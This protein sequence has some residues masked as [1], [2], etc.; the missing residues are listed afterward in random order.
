[1]VFLALTALISACSNSKPASSEEFQQNEAV[2]FQ[3]T[4]ITDD[5]GAVNS[6]WDSIDSSG[7]NDRLN[8]AIDADENAFVISSYSL[9]D[10]LADTNAPLAELV[11]IDLADLIFYLVDP[12]TRHYPK[13]DVD[14]FYPL[15]GPVYTA[16]FY[17][18]LDRMSGG[19]L[20]VPDDYISGL[21]DKL[22]RYAIHSIPRDSQG[23]LDEAWFND[24]VDELIDD[25]QK[26]TFQGDF[27]DV[28]TALNKLCLQTDYPMWVDDAGTPLNYADILP[29][30]DTNL[31]LGNAVAGTHDLV[32][33]LNRLVQSSG[34]RELVHNALTGLTGVLD[35]S[36]EAQLALRLRELIVNLE[37]NFTTGGAEY[38]ANPIYSEDDDVVYS[39]AELGQTLR[40]MLPMLAQLF[41]R[42]D[43]PN[44]MIVDQP[45]KP[46][47]YPLDLMLAY[48]K[49]IGFDPNA[50]DVEGSIDDVLRY[51]IY[52]RDRLTS[53]EA[54]PASLLES[55]LFLTEITS[56]Y[57]WQDGGATGEVTTSTDSRADHGHG[58][59]AENLT[60]NDSLFSIHMLKTLNLLGIYELSLKSTDGNHI[61]RSRTPYTLSDVDELYT[62]SVSGDDKDYRFFFDQ[63]YG[64]LQ[65][66][67]GPGPGDLGAPDG[68][69]SDGQSLGLNQ[70]LAYAPNGLHE[71]QLSAWTMGWGVRACFKGEG[72]YYYADPD[73]ETVVVDGQTYRQY[74]RPDGKIYALV[75][76][77]GSGYL[78][79]TNDG[80]AEDPET[81]ELS[82]NGKRQRD[83]R[84]KS[85]WH[86]DYY[87]GHYTALGVQHY[88]T[89]DNSSGDTQVVEVSDPASQAGSLVYQELIAETDPSRAC[90]SPEEAF[91]RNYQWV[92]NEKKMVLVVPFYMDELN[93][94][95]GLV[96]QLIECHGWS[97]LANV[98]KYGA[99][100]AWAKKG[101]AGLS[102]LPGDYRMEVVTAAP[103]LSTLAI[104]D[105]AVYNNNLDCGNA[106][107]PV[108][109]HNLAALTRLG[110]PRSPEMDRGDG[111]DYDLGSQ[112]FTVGDDI[113][114]HRNA[115]APLLFSLLAGLRDYAPAYDPDSRPGID[116]GMR[117][118]LNQVAALIKPLFYYNRTGP[119][120]DGPTHSWIPRVYGTI[121]PADAYQGSPFLKSSA[122][123]YSGTPDTWFG[124]WEERRYYQPAVLKSILNVM[125]DSNLD[126]SQQR[127]NG[128]LPLVTGSR[129]LTGLL[130][131]LLDASAGMPPL[132]HVVSAMKVTEGE[133]IRINAAPESNKSMVYPP[134]MFAQGVAASRDAYGAYTQYTGVRN[135][136]LVVDVLLDLIVGQD[137][138]DA[139][140][141]GYGLAN[142]PDD[143]TTDADWQDFYDDV[144][145]LADLLNVGSDYSI[146]PNLLD[147]VDRVFAR[148][149]LYTSDEV[150]G[151]LYTIGKVFG[152]FDSNESGWTYQGESRF[153]DLYNML[154]LRI[155]SINALIT[156]N[157]VADPEA[158]GGS[159][160]SYALGEHYHALVNL[161]ANMSGPDG[162]AEFL[163][164]TTTAPQDWETIFEDLGLFM[165]SPDI[166][167]SQSELWSTVAELLHQLAVAV[168]ETANTNMVNQILTDYGFQVN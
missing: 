76:P 141:P 155:P 45:G 131:L 41:M 112:D 20:Q 60:L 36:A 7:V 67:A 130:N 70:Y 154:V 4:A 71:T 86:S 101:T 61:Y 72:P 68:G 15:A 117:V 1:M 97:G 22:L 107:P 9:A 8:T 69:N 157:E 102:T 146:T 42:S 52:G 159:S 27:I 94:I 5:Y 144:G 121:D 96:F 81:A 165:A 161:L 163:L 6:A 24:E 104:N 44:A 168:N 59:Y 91:Y 14:S 110:F 74:L 149:A 54:W 55:L 13:V 100:H 119:V 118:F 148:D 129:A 138:V 35:P 156:L 64:V 17:G 147:L 79:P 12:Q 99:N 37:S 53:D 58:A 126:D 11:H 167:G 89:L 2:G 62:G 137:A 73:A 30:Q 114:N 109:G 23:D 39:D 78:Y 56:S 46:S 16:D 31:D 85:Q 151:L 93:T 153:E 49:S 10:I 40:E 145:T 116:A 18:F 47:V 139:D 25:L 48:L 80:D 142:Y 128:I 125:I 124:S 38:T 26:A 33:W 98:R 127:M 29:D 122:D 95:K 43:R 108:V 103:P 65:F 133:S 83:N 3:L 21:L 160:Q 111:G 143:K 50:I 28:T 150:T 82:F 123:F 84:Y 152:Y 132:E 19:G 166:A 113:W 57:G 106:T 92:M 164:N 63:D 51:D 75:T 162:L 87:M 32:M 88:F 134:W 105:T 115:L 90:A 158:A 120:S 34:S 77:D 66:L 140:N 135:E 136:D